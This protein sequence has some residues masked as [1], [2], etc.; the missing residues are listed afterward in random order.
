M[1]REF[2][3]KT[4]SSEPTPQENFKR[5][6]QA[7]NDENLQKVAKRSETLEKLANIGYKTTA[8]AGFVSLIPLLYVSDRIILQV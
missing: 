7:I 8:T 1:S 3:P 4:P 5:Y 2:L 6:M